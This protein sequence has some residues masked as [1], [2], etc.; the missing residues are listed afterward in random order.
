MRYMAPDGT[1]I[2]GEHNNDFC[3]YRVDWPEGA[4]VDEANYSHDPGV[5][6][7]TTTYDGCTVWL[8]ENIDEW[9]SHH[10]IHED[11]EPLSDGAAGAARAETACRKRVHLF[12]EIMATL[13]SDAPM[14]EAMELFADG[15]HA[16]ANAMRAQFEALKGASDSREAV[17]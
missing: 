12:R 15:Q 17:A 10:L 3:A 4:G 13:E 8:D 9:L 2:L 16:A 14:Y 6:W 5:E 7:A 1:P 11:A